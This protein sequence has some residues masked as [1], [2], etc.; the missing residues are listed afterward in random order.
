MHIRLP[1]EW[2]DQDGILLAW[3]HAETDWLPLLD[4]AQNCFTSLVR[5]ISRFE[6]VLLVTPEA[7]ALRAALADQDIDP[8]KVTIVELPTNDTWTRDFGPVTVQ[9]NGA[10]VMLDFGFNGWGLKFAANLDNQITRQLKQAGFL[11]PRLNTIGLILEGGSLESDGQGTILTTSQC[12]LSPNRNPQLDR[13]DIEDALTNLLGARRILW[14]EHGWLAGDDTDAHI[15]TLARLCP[16]NTIVY[17]SCPDPTDEH[18]EELRLMEQELA[19]FRT[20]DGNPY[21]LL[22]LPW[23]SAQYDNEGC[24]LPATYANFLVINNAVLVPT[25]N[26]PAD[27]AALAMIGLAFPGREIIAINSNILIRQHGSLH[28]VTMQLPKGVLP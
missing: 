18:Y 27:S 14:L 3:P 6:R 8:A 25:Y 28:C 23:P 11:L 2:E 9:V 4:E 13:S 22:P 7:V 26:D 12:L 1:A 20:V 16:D 10:P 5:A 19:A 15:D 17:V 24:R 21:R